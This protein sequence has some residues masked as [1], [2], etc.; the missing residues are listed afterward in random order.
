MPARTVPAPSATASAWRRWCAACAPLSPACA[1]FWACAI[2]MLRRRGN[3]G[4][5]W[6]SSPAGSNGRTATS[7]RPSRITSVPVPSWLTSTATR[8]PRPSPPSRYSKPRSPIFPDTLR[9]CASGKELIEWG[10]ED[11]FEIAVRFTATMSPRG[12][13]TARSWTMR[14]EKP[15]GT[16][17]GRAVKALPAVALAVS[18]ASIDA[19]ADGS[20]NWQQRPRQMRAVLNRLLA[21][22]ELGRRIDPARIGAVG[23]SAGGY[24]VLALIGAR[25]DLRLLAQ[26]CTV[27]IEVATVRVHRSSAHPVSACACGDQGRPPS[28]C[29]AKLTSGTI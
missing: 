15:G 13:E 4:P 17:R 5:G 16:S 29:H 8:L 12:F 6:R 10:F 9:A 18:L 28:I 23:H 2:G 14:L 24:T 7:V 27:H 21:D 11:D 25:A 19:R 26:H 1:C 22:P 3:A 20:T